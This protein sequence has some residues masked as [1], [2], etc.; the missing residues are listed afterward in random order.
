MFQGWH[1]TSYTNTISLISG[2]MII[3]SGVYLLDMVAPM[4]SLSSS[5]LLEIPFTSS[6]YR[7]SS[8]VAVNEKD[9]NWDDQSTTDTEGESLQPNMIRNRP[10]ALSV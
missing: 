1:T 10:R 5:S 3:F 8:S 2:F 4:T 7:V 6:S 9:S